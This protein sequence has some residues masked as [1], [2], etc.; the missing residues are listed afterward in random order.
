LLFQFNS[1]AGYLNLVIPFAI[2]CAVLAKDRG[3]KFLGLVCACV[4]SVAVFLTQSR[5]GLLALA[6][7]LIIAVWLLVPRLITRIEFLCGGALACILLFAPLLSHF[8]RLQGG[9]DDLGRL[10]LWQTAAT[11]FLDHPLLGVGYG[12]YRSLFSDFVPGAVPGTVDAH[13]LYLQLLAETGLV[14]FLS[15]MALLGGFLLLSLKSIREQDPLSRIIAFGVCG[16]I[17]ATLI[18]GMVDYLFNFSPQFGALF[19]LVLGLGSHIMSGI[20]RKMMYEAAPR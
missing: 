6:G 2:V 7:V 11:L 8:E 20:T 18:H 16:A 5:G 10:D 14:G 19:W 4:A 17:A 15:F 9:V 12:N 13:N 1:L 3:L